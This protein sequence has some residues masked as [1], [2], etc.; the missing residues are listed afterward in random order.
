[1]KA[2][3]RA[4]ELLKRA[5]QEH[6]SPRQMALAVA[7][8]ALVGTSPLLGLHLVVGAALATALRLNRALAVLG[9]N[10]S[11]GPILPLMVIGEVR[12]GS[13]L[14][15]K[16]LPPMTAENSV[17]IA[18]G[19]LG[20]W[21]VGFAAVG[22]A[23]ASLVGLVVYALASWRDRKRAATTPQGERPGLRRGPGVHG[24]GERRPRATAASR[25]ARGGPGPVTSG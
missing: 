25:G 8:G 23:V 19:A 3:E 2:L 24:E 4:R 13:W 18:R 14:L 9:T 10:V 20:A 7:L 11:F 6:A 21:L 22:P 12:L 5:L 17:E 16:T 1:M 15:G